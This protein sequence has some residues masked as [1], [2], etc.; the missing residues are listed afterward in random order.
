MDGHWGGG[1]ALGY[2]NAFINSVHDV[3]VALGSG[4]IPSPNFYDGLKN[5]KVLDAVLLSV[6]G[7]RWVRVCE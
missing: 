3:A 4:V 1:H 2:A 5:Q 6:Q 7:G